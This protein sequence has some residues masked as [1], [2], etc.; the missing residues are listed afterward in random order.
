MKKVRTQGSH[1]DGV[2]QRVILAMQNQKRHHIDGT[3]AERIPLC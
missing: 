2:E 1:D 3:R